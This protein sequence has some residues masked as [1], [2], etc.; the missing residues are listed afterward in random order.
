MTARPT[1]LSAGSQPTDQ[2]NHVAVAAM[3]EELVAQ[4][5]G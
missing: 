4:L 2:V 3:A 5:V 1:V